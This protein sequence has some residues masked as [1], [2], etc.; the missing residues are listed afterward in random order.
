MIIFCTK[1]LD[2]TRTLLTHS[3]GIAPGGSGGTCPPFF[4]IQGR[5]GLVF[6]FTLRHRVI[7][8]AQARSC[9]RLV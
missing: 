4:Y 9:A 3:I 1:L 8:R 5:R 2:M 7:V 6:F